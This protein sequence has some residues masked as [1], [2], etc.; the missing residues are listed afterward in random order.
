[1]AY[2]VP[3]LATTRLTAEINLLAIGD[4][5]AINTVS[6]VYVPSAPEEEYMHQMGLNGCVR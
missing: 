2:S 4:L 3:A 6:F 5:I 1:M